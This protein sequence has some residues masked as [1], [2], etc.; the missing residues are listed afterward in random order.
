MVEGHK[1][2]GEKKYVLTKY[3]KTKKGVKVQQSDHNSLVTTVRTT[4]SKKIK[5]KPTEM[6][7]IKDKNGLK[8]FYD[9]TSR[10]TFLSEIFN[11]E[12]KKI[13]VKTKQFTKRLK[14][15]M[16]KCFRKIRIGP[17]KRNKELEK[18]FT[19]RRI[20]KNKT[21]EQSLE[22][23]KTVEEK[24]ANM[25]AEDNLK[26]VNESCQGLVGEE[27]GVNV[28]KLWI[29]KRRL[30]GIIVEPPTAMLDSMGN[31]VTSRSGIE[32]L[33][34]NTFQ[35]RLKP[36]KIREDLQVYEKQREELCDKRLKKAQENKTPPWT[37]E[38]LDI[39][40]KQLKTN[41]SRDPLGFG[42]EL[43]RPENAGSDLKLAVLKMM[44]QVKDQQVVPTSF[45]YC[46]ISSLYKQKGCKKDFDNYR[47]IFRVTVLRSI[48]DKLIYNDE[49]QNIDKNLTDSNVG[50]RRGRNIRYNIF[51][52]NAITN[53]I[54]R[55]KLKGVDITIYD[56][57]KCFDK[58]WTKE[59]VNDL[60]EKG[61]QNDKL[62]LLHMGNM[63]AKVAVKI[64]GGIT[65]RFTIGENV[66]QGTVWG[67][68]TCTC[69]MDSLAKKMNKVPEKLY[70][71]KGVLIPPLEM[72]DDI[73][74]VTDV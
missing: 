42:N 52:I 55:H 18:L 68:L 2:D 44:N 61:F 74:T 41:K 7:N 14:F 34:V 3:R 24:L 38:D 56:V 11:D 17:S 36:W 30:R 59:C 50:A 65:E 35:E 4:W 57:M 28:K 6:Y 39:V 10:D 67:S 48:L 5:S 22:S 29:L 70:N 23:L 62:C 45:K 47:G 72:V 21:D 19:M 9:M 31:L 54:S 53:Q 63:N 1:I 60:F 8:Q 40:L 43:F 64:A 46:N 33:T 37:L 58:L 25:C 13:E 26:I 73:L 71:Y 32:K 27:G 16:S 12:S 49:Y 20:L 69:T 51:I 66:M 15:L